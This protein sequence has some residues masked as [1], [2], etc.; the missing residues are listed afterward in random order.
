MIVKA[1]KQNG[2]KIYKDAFTGEEIP[3]TDPQEI[4]KSLE[5]KNEILRRKIWSL[6]KKIDELEN[7]DY[8][9]FR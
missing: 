8:S 6:E 5:W 1:L 3:I 4:I 9:V 7:F 2:S